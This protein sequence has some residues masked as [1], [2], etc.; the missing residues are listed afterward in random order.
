MVDLTLVLLETGGYALYEGDAYLLA[1]DTIAEIGVY[2]AGTYG[3]YYN[4]EIGG[5]A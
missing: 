2:V 4:L 3:V 5:A 1:A